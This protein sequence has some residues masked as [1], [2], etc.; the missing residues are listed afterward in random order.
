MHQG[1]ARRRTLSSCRRA[2]IRDGLAAAAAGCGARI[3][4]RARV[5][6]LEVDASSA[7]V[8]GVV[9]AGGERMEADV[10][11]CNRDLPAAYDLL[12]SSQQAAAGEPEQP[13]TGGGQGD[14]WVE[15]YA[16]RRG[17]QLGRLS[18]SAGV[19]AFSWCL[20]RRIDCLLH[21]NVFLSEDYE[22]SWAPVTAPADLP[23]SPNFYVHAPARTDPGAAPPGCDSVMVLLPVAGMH[24]HPTGARATAGVEPPP[25]YP[26]GLWGH[27][28]SAPTP[29]ALLF[30]P[31][32]FATLGTGDY[33]EL[34]D[35]GREA[36][37]RTLSAAGA[38]DVR[39][40][41]R[42]E[43]VIA[44][45]EWKARYGLRHGAAFGL[46]HGLPQLSVLRPSNRDTR[47]GGL[48]FVGA[49]T[50]P[51]NGVPL[52]LI[53]ARLAARRVLRDLGLPPE[54]PPA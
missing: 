28:R 7:R 46:A 11:L 20:D 5:E 31:I 42:S 2:Q 35:A 38:G 25:T 49:S 32:P 30:R 27:Q 8:T 53:G 34:I 1:P 37:L 43:R 54:A 52:A 18:Y 19:I 39:S 10:V 4:T 33:G 12:R 17:E 21:H 6:A 9:L 22:R 47:V 36:V 24:Q 26:L 16:R 41:I 45:P 50:A 3:R 29:W 40:A 23:R 51:G 14:G 15:S 13:G 44:P 48:Y